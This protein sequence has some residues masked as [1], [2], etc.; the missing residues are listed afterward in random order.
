MLM[1][2]VGRGSM[3]VKNITAAARGPTFGGK[4]AVRNWQ[5]RA[6]KSIHI[7]SYLRFRSLLS[8]LLEH[9]TADCLFLL[10]RFWI[11]S[12][13]FSALPFC[14]HSQHH[15]YFGSNHPHFVPHSLSLMMG[16]LE[17]YILSHLCYGDCKDHQQPA[18][19]WED[20]YTTFFVP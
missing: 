2:V 18:E 1:T 10:F 11:Y 19:C 9:W 13:C 12:W 17:Y 3:S 20:G 8:L 5:R 16:A 15:Y 14:I 6:Q 4:L 7:P